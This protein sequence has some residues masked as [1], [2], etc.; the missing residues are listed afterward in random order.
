MKYLLTIFLSLFIFSAHSKNNCSDE[1]YADS[2]RNWGNFSSEDHY[3]FNI[4]LKKAF[5]EK[6]LKLLMSLMVEEDYENELIK[7]NI[8]KIN[9]EE[10]LEKSLI[11]DVIKEEINCYAHYLNGFMVSQGSLWYQYD[12]ELNI[13]YISYLSFNNKVI[14]SIDIGVNSDGTYLDY[15]EWIHNEKIIN[16]SCFSYYWIGSGDNY[17]EYEEKFGISSDCDFF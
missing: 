11:K 17:E 7:K 6:N 12:A 16:P 4:K 8:D 3:E 5:K 10:L 2:R 14:N 9:F 13:F 15:V 1:D